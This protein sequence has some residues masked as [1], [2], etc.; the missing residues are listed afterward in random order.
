[1]RWQEEGSEEKLGAIV[2]ARLDS[3]RLRVIEVESVSD[4][5]ELM[6]AAGL[7]EMFQ[8]IFRIG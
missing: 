2:G 1:V 7:E 5:G 4:V 3:S 6:R 8:S